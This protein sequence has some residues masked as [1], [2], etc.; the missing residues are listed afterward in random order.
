MATLED[1]SVVHASRIVGGFV[2]GKRVVNKWIKPEMLEEP[3]KRRWRAS[4]HR[5]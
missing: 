4:R 1:G 3:Q 5:S 2:D